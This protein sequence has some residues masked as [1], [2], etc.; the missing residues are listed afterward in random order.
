MGARRG[1]R[2]VL[3][4]TGPAERVARPVP[5]ILNWRLAESWP[6][7]IVDSFPYL[8]K[9]FSAPHNYSVLVSRVSFLS[10]PKPACVHH[11]SINIEP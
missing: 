11:V 1:K 4:F 5:A 10:L 2:L 7:L 6:S 8:V 9:E 3:L